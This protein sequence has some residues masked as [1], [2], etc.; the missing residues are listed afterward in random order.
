MLIERFVF[1]SFS[2]LLSD[3]INRRALIR[4]TAATAAYT[5]L[6]HNAKQGLGGAEGSVFLLLSLMILMRS[7][8]PDAAVV[9]TFSLTRFLFFFFFLIVRHKDAYKQHTHDFVVWYSVF[10]FSFPSWFIFVPLGRLKIPAA[11]AAASKCDERRTNGRTD[12]PAVA[13]ESTE[14]QV[15]VGS[16]EKEMC[17]WVG[18]YSRCCRLLA[19]TKKLRL[20]KQHIASS[21]SSL[22]IYP[23]SIH[24]ATLFFLSSPWVP[25][26]AG[27]RG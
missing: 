12:R 25:H 6:C 22:G 21:S 13:V 24:P 10:F 3:Q 26:P 23:P 8:R 16:S 27:A 1:F 7:D 17:A 4:A 14:E 19:F 15:V 18:S 9:R 11:S 20:Y 5:R 2:F